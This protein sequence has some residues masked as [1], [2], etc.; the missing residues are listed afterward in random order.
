M[1]ESPSRCAEMGEHNRRVVKERYGWGRV[2]DRLEDA[3]DAAVRGRNAHM[4]A[5]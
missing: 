2:I 3:Y 1:L 5:R 4:L